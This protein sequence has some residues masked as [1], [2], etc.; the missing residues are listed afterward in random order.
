MLE[1]TDYEL[2]SY[3]FNWRERSIDK[4]SSMLGESKD[5]IKNSIKRINN[6]LDYSIYIDNDEMVSIIDKYIDNIY[7]LENININMLIRYLS[8]ENR[9]S[10]ILLYL[11]VHNKFVSLHDIAELMGVSKNTALNDIK[12]L[13][14]ELEKREIKIIYFRNEGYKIEGNEFTIRQIINEEVNSLLFVPVGKYLLSELEIVDLNEKFLLKQRLEKTEKR[15]SIVLSDEFFG[16]LPYSLLAII[17][18]IENF[19]VHYKFENQFKELKDSKEYI[20]MVSVFWNY[21]FLEE[22]D[23][24][25]LVLFILSSNVVSK[26]SLEE[27]IP[28]EI[29]GID[30]TVDMFISALEKR[31]AIKFYNKNKLKKIL[32]QHLIPAIYRNL[33]GLE[34]VNPIGDQFIIEYDSVNTIVKQEMH[35]FEQY[36]RNFFSKDEVTYITMIVLSNLIETRKVLEPK[37]FTGVVICK[38]GTSISKLLIEQLKNL[39]PNIEFSKVMSLREFEEKGTNKDFIFSTVPINSRG[40]IFLVSSFMTEEERFRLKEN[41]EMTI[42][43]DNQKKTKYIITYLSEYLKEGTED[44]ATKKLHKL[45][46]NDEEKKPIK[47]KKFFSSTTQISIITKKIDWEGLIDLSFKELLKRNSVTNHYVK[48][49][50]KIFGEFYDS[51]LISPGVLIPH[52]PTDEGVYFPDVQINLLEKAV[53]SPNNKEYRLVIALAPGENNEHLDW[54]IELN[55]KLSNYEF[56]KQVFNTLSIEELFNLLGENENSY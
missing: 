2:L 16:N 44:E 39:F 41:V 24:E 33:L 7:Q 27:I 32:I 13:K 9:R 5:E 3:L 1:H 10:A 56:R 18:R 46:L 40:N 8:I 23:L 37:T 54:L 42:N 36:T 43:S 22:N 30:Q 12:K 4:I 52:A 45:F 34:I 51:M 50:K 31:L 47:S 35:H 14:L 49:C 28:A 38:N 55:K 26:G 19:R 6:H 53:I 48:I 17:K 29:R 11:L 20:T 25:Y 15:L 21:D